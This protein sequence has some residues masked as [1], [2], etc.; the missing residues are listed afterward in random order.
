[1]APTAGRTSLEP[2]GARLRRQRRRLPPRGELALATL[3]F[4]LRAEEASSLVVF[5]LVVTSTVVL[6]GL[7][8]VTVCNLLRFVHAR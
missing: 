2:W 6:I 7:R 1:M 5:A 8:R 4:T 3:P